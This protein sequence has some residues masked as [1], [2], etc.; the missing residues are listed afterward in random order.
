MQTSEHQRA[1]GIFANQQDT[2]QSLNELNASGFPMNHV[3][4][5]VKQADED[6]EFGGAQASDRIG[7]QNVNTP[8]GVVNDTVAASSWGFILAGLTSLV[9]PG[10]GPILAAGSLGAALVAATAS[11]GIGA[12]A[13]H[14]IVKALTQLGIPESQAGLY[15]DRVLQGN[16][17]VMVE[18]NADQIQ[19]A[20]QVF[21]HYPIKNWG[22]YTAL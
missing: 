22:I 2:E 10:I 4:I 16:Y 9:L 15:S 7:G 6:A 20:E 12:L 5:V 19:S 14:N 13:A 17:L 18:G 3:S 8:L 11:T 21:S 1:F